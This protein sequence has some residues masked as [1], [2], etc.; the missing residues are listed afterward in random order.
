MRKF[1]VEFKKLFKIYPSDY[2]GG[3][4]SYTAVKNL[5]IAL[6]FASF[7]LCQRT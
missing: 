5:L 1:I 6:L 4:S 2:F 3:S 7:S